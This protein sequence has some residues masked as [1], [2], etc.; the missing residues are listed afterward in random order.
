[1]AGLL[2]GI[3]TQGGILMLS[4]WQTSRRSAS[5]PSPPIE[6]RDGGRPRLPEL[7]SATPAAAALFGE[8]GPEAGVENSA[9]LDDTGLLPCADLCSK[10][11]SQQE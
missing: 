6:T 2:K 11:T 1:M 4:G 10:I 7:P 3:H 8:G 5:T 9:P